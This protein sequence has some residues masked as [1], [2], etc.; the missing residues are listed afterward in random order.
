M[1]SKSPATHSRIKD[2]KTYSLLE[3]VELGMLG[4]SHH[5]VSSAILHD[6]FGANILKAEIIG[7]GKGAR[8]RVLGKSLKAYAKRI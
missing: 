2:T 8:Y 6:R 3:I 5:T 7:T 4:K 1:A